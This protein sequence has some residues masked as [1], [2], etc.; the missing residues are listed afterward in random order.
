MKV[1]D[2]LKCTQTNPKYP[3]YVGIDT[4]LVVNIDNEKV[5]VISLQAG[6]CI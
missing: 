6:C 3:Q 1:L 5:N 2:V 4:F